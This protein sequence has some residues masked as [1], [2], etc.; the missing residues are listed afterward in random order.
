VQ[1]EKKEAYVFKGNKAK[2]S[3]FLDVI[4]DINSADQ[5]GDAE[6][7][8]TKKAKVEPVEG[9]GEAEGAGVKALEDAEA[10]K[11]ADS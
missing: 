7:P 2:K 9:G 8:P 10:E 5:A 11:E 1:D 6:E 3:I 4:P